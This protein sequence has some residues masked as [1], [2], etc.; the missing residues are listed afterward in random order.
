MIVRRSASYRIMPWANG[1]GQTVEMLREDGPAGL[2]LRLSIA[3][4]A[5]NG[6]FS[7]FPGIDRVLT[8]ISGPGF[9]LTGSGLHVHAAPLHP[10]TFPGDVEIAATGVTSASE[11]FNVMTAR[12]LPT[13]RVWIASAGRIKPEGR[14]FLLP[15]GD[16][17]L[18]G[19]IIGARD[20]IETDAPLTIV[21]DWP[22][23]VVEL[24]A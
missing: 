18:D 8:V 9:H 1:R 12:H 7:L 3:T 13:P 23:I 17:T 24:P 21:T 15:L 2:C 19:A 11:D 16:A 4:V 20:L 5:E 10:V 22:V 14:T 6:A